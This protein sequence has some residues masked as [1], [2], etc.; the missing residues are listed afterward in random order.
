MTRRKNTGNIKGVPA[1]VRDNIMNLRAARVSLFM[2]PHDLAKE[3]KISQCSIR[4]YENYDRMPSRDT[5]NKLAAVL[6]WKV[7][8]EDKKGAY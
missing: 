7:W 2:T 4:D 6:G 3:A 8:R 5:Y 1:F